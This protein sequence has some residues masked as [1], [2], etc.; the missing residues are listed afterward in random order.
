MP[1]APPVPLLVI[2]C[3]VRPDRIGFYMWRA[4]K[5]NGGKDLNFLASHTCIYLHPV[6]CQCCRFCQV[7]GVGSSGSIRRFSVLRAGICENSAPLLVYVWCMFWC[8]FGVSNLQLYTKRK[9]LAYV[10]LLRLV[11]L[12]YLFFNLYRK[13]A[14]TKHTTLFIFY[15]FLKEVVF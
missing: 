4:K 14:H 10:V 3:N 12:V 8:I 9:R 1:A 11:Y 13:R 5:G 15:F 2:A 6:N 7:G